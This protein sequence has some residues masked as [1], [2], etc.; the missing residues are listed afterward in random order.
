MLLHCL[1]VS[2]VSETYGVLFITFFLLLEKLSQSQ[3]A[4]HHPPAPSSHPHMVISGPAKAGWRL[5]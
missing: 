3:L 2:A 4:M 5:P 1:S